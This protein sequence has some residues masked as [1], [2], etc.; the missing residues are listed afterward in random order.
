VGGMNE[1]SLLSESIERAALADLHAAAPEE[2][3]RLLG[4]NLETI[5]TALVAIATR[6]PNILLNRTIGPGVEAPD[7]QEVVR[8]IA[9][10]YADDGVERYFLHLHPDARP[11]ELREWMAR[12]GLVRYRGWAKFHRG[13]AA[14]PGSRSELRVQRVGTE[15]AVEFGRIA[16]EGFGLS[17]A[18]IPLLASLVDRPGWHLYMSFAGDTPAGTGAMFVREEAAWLDWGST[19][20][21]YRGRGGQGMVLCRRIRDA[22]ALGCRTL[23]TTTGEEVAGDPQHSYKNIVRTGFRPVYVRENFVPAS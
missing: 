3:R 21:A 6:E 7:T 5:G 4:L 14:P 8:A 11:P 13:P 10:R 12:A 1:I 20:P 17:E 18:A 22:L 19:L 2:T 15:H 16:A 9:S 23:L